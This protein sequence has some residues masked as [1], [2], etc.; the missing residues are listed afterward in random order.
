MAIKN[1][2][3]FIL[4]L[5]PVV[6]FAQER[7]PLTGRVQVNGGN[8]IGIFVINTV[9]GTEVRTD[10][11]SKFTLP[12]KPGDKLAVYGKNIEDRQFAVSKDSFTQTPY[13]LEVNAKATQLQEV[14]INDV[15]EEKLGLVPK[16]QIRMTVA[17]RRVHTAKSGIGLDLLLNVLS[18]RLKMLKKA[19]ETERKEQL[20]AVI[21]GIFTDEELANMGV[22]RD[23]A[24]G[25]LFYAIEDPKMADAIR[26]KN[27]SLMKLTLM[28]LSD[29][30][31][32]LQNQHE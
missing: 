29:K 3:L 19:L 15:N 25:F 26:S 5:C 31:N 10:K 24:R 11:D 7:R 16:D 27:E 20:M 12:A 9:T 2:I 23:L 21:D 1:L 14:V 32:K 8:S 30:Y 22:P 28:E 6:T 18:G 13:V 4:C 17:E